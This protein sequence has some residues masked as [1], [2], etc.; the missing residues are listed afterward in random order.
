M[1]PRPH[2]RAFT[3]R[4]FGVLLSSA[5]AADVWDQRAFAQHAP[6]DLRFPKFSRGV[7]LHHVLNWPDTKSGTAK[8]EYEWPPFEAPNYQISDE[9]LARLRAMGF[10]FLRVT[11][12]PSI[13]IAVDKA[14][15]EYLKELVR[16]TMN[17]FISA[18]FKVIFD[19]HPVSVNPEYAPLKLV[20]SID[21]AAFRGYTDLVEQIARSLD[22]L[23][24][25]KFAFE[26]MNEPWLASEA[27]VARW[28]P[29]LEALHRRAREG[30]PTLPLVLSG[31]QWGDAK[32]LMQLNLRA[33]KGS[34]VLYTFHYY[35]PHTYTQQ[36]VEGDDG[37]FLA[38]LQWPVSHENI[39]KARD[40]ALARIDATKQLPATL[41]RIKE[42]TRK[43]LSDYEL[44]AHDRNRMR[45]DFGAVAAW[46]SREGVPR[47][48]IFLGE[49]GCVASAH[50]SPL[51]DDRV[52]W[53]RAIRDTAQEFG[54]AWAL[55][56]YKGY[57]GMALYD[58][59]KIDKG[60]AKALDLPP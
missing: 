28:Q 9:E 39:A 35:D 43:L 21:S 8:T 24:H 2:Q 22:D 33:F 60:I 55:W 30:S 45:N 59:G 49:F 44:T 17:R 53:L 58:E 47:E 5:W 14:R 7:N 6:A 18:G 29:M 41:Q 51:G 46:A 26:L 37:E 34:N 16:R 11:A 48:R 42:A 32:A 23:P 19:L 56:A 50:Q 12:D 3:R 27:E 10:D 40:A 38:G 54:F 31:A 4:S 52:Q 15:Q 36:G 1:T 13:F 20:E 25:E 57:G